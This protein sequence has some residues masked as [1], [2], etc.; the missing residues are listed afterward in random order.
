MYAAPIDMMLA[1]KLLPLRALREILKMS[2]EPKNVKVVID[3][4]EPKGTADGF[5]QVRPAAEANEDRR[6]MIDAAVN[7]IMSKNA[8]L[9]RKL[10]E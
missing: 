4:D 6:A 10:A 9:L 5:A 8:K 2:Q 3:G 1:R 7:D